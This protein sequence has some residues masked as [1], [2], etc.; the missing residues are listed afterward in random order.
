MMEDI[1]IQIVCLLDPVQCHK[2]LVSILSSHCVSGMIH[3][4]LQAIKAELT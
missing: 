3:P 1:L 4:S 2:E